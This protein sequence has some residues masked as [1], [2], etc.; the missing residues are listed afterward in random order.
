MISMV[1]P[2]IVI[3]ESFHHPQP[4]RGSS[5]LL[6]GQNMTQNG[7]KNSLKQPKATKSAFVYFNLYRN[8][9]HHNINFHIQ[10]LKDMFN[11]QTLVVSVFPKYNPLFCISTT[12]GRGHPWSKNVFRS[13]TSVFCVNKWTFLAKRTEM[14]PEVIISKPHH[15][16]LAQRRSRATAKMGSKMFPLLYI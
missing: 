5:A 8:F 13:S 1:W 6:R 7:S 3:S 9:N 12:W 11:P 16:P 10:F 15:H 4:Q 14:W 2:E